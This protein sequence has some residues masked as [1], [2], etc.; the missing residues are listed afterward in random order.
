MTPMGMAEYAHG[1]RTHI[2]SQPVLGWVWHSNIACCALDEGVCHKV[3]NQIA[4]RFMK[5]AFG[6]DSMKQDEW[7][8]FEEIWADIEEAEKLHAESGNA[9]SPQ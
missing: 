8:Q 2:Q 6:F 9:E 7:K 4:A 3:A 5:M 1:V